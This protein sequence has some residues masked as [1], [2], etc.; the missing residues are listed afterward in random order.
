MSTLTYFGHCAFLWVS[1]SGTR[2]L[3][4][5]FGNSPTSHWFHDLFPHVENDVT[6]V[7]HDHFDHNAIERVPGLPTL[8]RGPCEFR[9]NDVAIRGVLDLHSGRSGL[10]GLQNTMFAIEIEGVRFCHLGDNRHDFPEAAREQ[11]GD[12]DVLMVTV[13][14]SC[15]L[16]SYEQVGSLIARLE[17]RVVMPM[18]YFI[19]GVTT[20]R[21]TTSGS[22]L[23][24][25]T[26]WLSTQGEVKHLS[27]KALEISRDSLPPSREV[28]MLKSVLP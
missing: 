1:P 27:G 4:D 24:P 15:H 14:D 20:D 28:W 13:D 12:V 3:I 23:E 16:L 5:P 6:I 19:E 9:L 18:H 22:P 10:Q 2:V 7:T 26:K 25:P 11:I 17:P 21:V 8:L